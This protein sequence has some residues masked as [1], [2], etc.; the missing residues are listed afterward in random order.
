MQNEILEKPSKA[1]RQVKP[2]IIRKS[3]HGG[4]AEGS[5]FN[6]TVTGHADASKYNKTAKGAQNDEEPSLLTDEQKEQLQPKEVKV[7]NPWIHEQ[8]HQ[9]Y[10]ENVKGLPA[11]H[12]NVIK[13]HKSVVKEKTF[14]PIVENT[15]LKDQAA[16][17]AAEILDAE[18][19]IFN[20]DSNMSH[21]KA[22]TRYDTWDRDRSV[23][24]WLEWCKARPDQP[25]ALS[26]V[27]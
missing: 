11:R 9:E 23:E 25:H 5:N 20:E 2:F 17:E 7:V 3:Q 1:K 16:K 18:Y 26:P 8:T 24:E 10:L 13:K 4:A 6:A 22:L 15:T 27:F 19:K 12:A 21:V 14:L